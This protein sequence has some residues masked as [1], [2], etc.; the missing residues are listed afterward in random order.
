VAYAQRPGLGIVP[1]LV[2]VAVDLG[3]KEIKAI[4]AGHSATYEETLQ[5]IPTL[6][7]EATQQSNVCAYIVLQSL[8]GNQAYCRAAIDT[9]GQIGTTPGE[10]GPCGGSGDE[11]KSAARSA[12]VAVNQNNPTVAAQAANAVGTVPDAG[13]NAVVGVAGITG[14]S[15]AVALTKQVGGIPVWVYAALGLGAVLVLKD[16]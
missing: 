7:Q 4:F 14:T 12:V 15:V 10:P 9:C 16:A 1:I 3:V 13:V 2:G 5:L 6:Q 11:T 8:S